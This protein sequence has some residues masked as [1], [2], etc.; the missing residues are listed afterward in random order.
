MND[1]DAEMEYGI[2]VVFASI[3][4]SA[5]SQVVEKLPGKP[6][7][8]KLK[9][10]P[11]WAASEEQIE[12]LL[13][14]RKVE[15]HGYIKSETMRD[16]ASA[17]V[18]R[19]PYSQLETGDLAVRSRFTLPGLCRMCFDTVCLQF[20]ARCGRKQ[21]ISSNATSQRLHGTPSYLTI[22]ASKEL[23]LCLNDHQVATQ[24]SDGGRF[25]E[26][27]RNCFEVCLSSR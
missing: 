22:F 19:T 8:V 2:Q 1:V 24:A 21:A 6:D 26:Q 3:P 5:Y 13:T 4:H 11:A 20:T 25:H 9:L 15:P 14:E 7:N 27:K 16:I 10:D 18:T 23:I 17:A 12:T